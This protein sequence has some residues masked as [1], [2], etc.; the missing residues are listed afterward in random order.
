[1]ENK[2]REHG[3]VVEVTCL[4]EVSS[5]QLA[6]ADLVM[7]NAF[8]QLEG[9]L[10]TVVKRVRL[11]SRVPL[12]MVTNGH[13]TEQL[14]VALMAGVDAIWSLHTSTDVLVARCKA[15]LRRWIG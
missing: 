7:F 2:L 1:I 4:E 14:V 15:V 12:I 10:E 9:I 5:D 11:E 8:E 13:S 6:A 3:L